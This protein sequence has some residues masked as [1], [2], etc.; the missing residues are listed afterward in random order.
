MPPAV[1]EGVST[2]TS[3]AATGA[4]TSVLSKLIGVKGAAIFG[5]AAL[6]VTSVVVLNQKGETPVEALPV[7]PQVEEQVAQNIQEG[8]NEKDNNKLVVT[9]EDV[10]HVEEEAAVSYVEE[11]S[12]Y[13]ENRAGETTPEVVLPGSEETGNVSSEETLGHE[14]NGETGA[15]T[16][17]AERADI[18]LK[19]SSS[20]CCVNET[21][22]F[23]ITSNQNLKQVVWKLNGKQVAESKLVTRLLFETKGSYTIEVL[24]KDEHN[25][26]VGA[27]TKI[28]VG[29]ASAEFD[30]DQQGNELL[31][32]ALNPAINNQWYSNQVMV[33]ENVPAIV[34]NGTS[35]DKVS[36]VHTVTDA[37]GCKDTARQ[38]IT[39]EARC[40]VDVNI[41]NVFTPYFQDGKNDVF[42]VS[43]P[44]VDQYWLS[45]YNANGQMVFETQDQNEAWN[46]KRYN[47]GELLPP[48]TYTYQL[49]Y[50]CNGVTKKMSDKV[51]L[52]K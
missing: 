42:S 13:E 28:N 52:T 16:S 43:I 48:G 3:G 20:T 1:W 17:G 51:S 45:I 10:A 8:Q 35:G 29:A 21:I 32:Q 26:L 18:Q 46:G 49:V 14:E 50:G 34:L 27:N 31:V 36:I 41:H 12:A 33:E 37:N 9:P 22:D 23:E 39:I 2:A 15:K 24:G 30:V 38:M 6:V 19:G 40:D 5:G 4:T 7:E 11:M 25:H 47:Q 44:P